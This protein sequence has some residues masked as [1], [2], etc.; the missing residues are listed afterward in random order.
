MRRHSR[1]RVHESSAEPDVVAACRLAAAP[2]RP[3]LGGGG[4]VGSYMTPLKGALEQQQQPSA[5]RM[6][7]VAAA[8]PRLLPDGR[9]VYIE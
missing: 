3:P 9:I 4:G 6:S 8:T 2:A 5:S 1:I 7:V